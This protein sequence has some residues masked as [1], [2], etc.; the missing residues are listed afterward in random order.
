MTESRDEQASRS[1]D[2]LG[3]AVAVV[4]V[5]GLAFGT[6]RGQ[7]TGWHGA[8]AYISLAAGATAA[9][10][11]PILM[12]RSA[13]PLVPPSLFW[14]RN[15]TVTNASTFLIYGAL[16]VALT[17]LGL[18]LI[19]TLGYNEPAAGIA[20]LPADILLVL[21]STRAGRLA[22]RYGSRIFLVVGPA[23]MAAGL[24]WLTQVPAASSAWVLT[25]GSS[26]SVLPPPDYVKHFFPGLVVF[27]L[28]LVLL[29]APLTA[30]VMTSVP[31]HNAG[32][33]SAVNNAISRV[34]APLVTGV[35]FVVVVS[36]FYG[37]LAE[38]AACCRR[39]GGVFSSRRRTFQRT[40][41]RGWS[42]RRTSGNGGLDRRLPRGDA[43]SRGIACS[44]C[45][46]QRAG[47]RRAPRTPRSGASRCPGRAGPADRVGA[48]PILLTWYTQIPERPVVTRRPGRSSLR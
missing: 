32:V 23:A 20:M 35:I 9:V 11:F 38:Q 41:R 43:G 30:A 14:S 29:V 22:A 6:I 5:A 19:G 15:F 17:F 45:G 3:S 16:Y 26:G 25:T 13:H 10:M 42:A 18:F 46:G 2:W 4:A 48:G 1:L 44:G 36:G 37:A 21:F 33:A 39:D 34:G 27:G 47:H 31:E 28:G 7:Q 12:M 40:R 24:L 8:E